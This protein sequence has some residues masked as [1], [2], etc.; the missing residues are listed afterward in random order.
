MDERDTKIKTPHEEALDLLTLLFNAE[1][2]YQFADQEYEHAKDARKMAKEEVQRLLL[3]MRGEVP[4]MHAKARERN[5][6]E[7][8]L[9]DAPPIVEWQSDLE[10]IVGGANDGA[11]VKDVSIDTDDLAGDVI[12][13]GKGLRFGRFKAR[14][15]READENVKQD[16][17]DLECMDCSKQ[18]AHVFVSPGEEPIGRLRQS[19]KQHLD[20]FHEREK[21]DGGE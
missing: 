3:I 8:T 11:K 4:R 15:T 21:R 14:R 19:A 9:F 2:R 17:Y 18:V 16:E 7:G 13:D 6:L 5:A 10:T 1:Q 20:L 12:S